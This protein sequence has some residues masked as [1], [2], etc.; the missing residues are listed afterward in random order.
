MRTT[1]PAPA[2]RILL[3]GVL[4]FGTL[5]SAARAADTMEDRIDKLILQ[6]VKPDGPGCAVLVVDDGKIVFERAYG[7]ADMETGRPITTA[8]AFDIGSVTKQFTAACIALLAEQGQISLDEDIRKYLPEMPAYEAPVQIKHLIHHISGVRDFVL[9]SFLKGLPVGETY[10]EP[11]L[12]DLLTRQKELNFRPGEAQSYSNSGYFLLG[13]IVKRVTGMSV[14]EYAEKHLFDPL[15]MMRTSYHRDPERIGENVAIGHAAQGEGKYRRTNVAPDTRDLGFGGICTTV[16]DMYRWDQNFYKNKIG[17][18]NFN[19][20]LQTTG[21]LNN[22]DRLT[23]AF[24]LSMGEHGGLRTASHQGG[25]LGYNAFIVRF[26]ERKFSVICLANYALHT[27]RLSYEIAD[28]YLGIPKETPAPAHAPVTCTVAEVDPAVYA[29]LVGKY[30]VNDGAVMPITTQN[31]RLYVQP[32]GAPLLELFPKSTTEYFLKVVN[33]Q[34]SF[35]PSENGKAT[36]LI[37]HQNGHHIPAERLDDR[38]LRPG[39]LNEYEGEYYSEELQIAYGVYVREDRLC[40]KAP[41]VPEVFQRNFRDPPGENVL[42]HLGGDRFVRS[43]GMVE[44]SRDDNG[45]I[46][47]FTLHAGGDLKNLRFSKR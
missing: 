14:G 29:G 4:I 10:D 35:F 43:Y 38:P 34:L 26:P 46:A 44:F 37:W 33:V 41:R 17:S 32:P 8:T 36:K 6:T 45:K 27:T 19:T 30:C 47:G 39:Q 22:G 1:T 24:G 7:I 11:V 18:E 3:L 16:E 21:T 15:G 31:N 9:L 25:S 28:L 20:L 2:S 13:V 40:L 42:R 23:Y 5:S 12:F